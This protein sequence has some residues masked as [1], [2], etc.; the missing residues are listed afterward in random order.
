[1]T[2][3]APAAVSTGHADDDL[4]HIYCDDCDVTRSLCGLDLTGFQLDDAD[5]PWVPDRDT[6]VVCLEVGKSHVCR[7]QVAS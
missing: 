1:M 6:C 3:P 7:T 5:T 2:T 4:D